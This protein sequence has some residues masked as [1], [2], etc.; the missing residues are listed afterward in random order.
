[1]II[2]NSAE[3]EQWGTR[4]ETECLVLV[5][6]ASGGV[7]RPGGRRALSNLGEISRDINKNTRF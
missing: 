4:V 6:E 7:Y 2:N 1:M 3:C 5:P